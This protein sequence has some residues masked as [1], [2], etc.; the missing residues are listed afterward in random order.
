MRLPAF[1]QGARPRPVFSIIIGFAT[2]DVRSI[3]LLREVFAYHTAS[4][5]SPS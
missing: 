2:P 5:I 1:R 4:P 3:A